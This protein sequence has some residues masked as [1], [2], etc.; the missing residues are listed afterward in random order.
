LVQAWLKSKFED[1][2]LDKKKWP[3]RSPDLNPC[4]YYLWGY[5]KYRVYRP[6]PKTLD[7]LKANIE[8]EIKNINKK[9]LENVFLNLKK[10]CDSV[11]EKSGGHFE[12][13]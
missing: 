1:K 6:L 5:L 9:I 13:K 8:R 3:P 2:F 12:N 10:R 7:Q 11:I 4:D